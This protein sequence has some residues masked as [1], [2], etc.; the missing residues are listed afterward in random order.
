MRSVASGFDGGSGLI[1]VEPDGRVADVLREQRVEAGRPLVGG[2]RVERG[3]LLGRQQRA[4]SAGSWMTNGPSTRSMFGS[5]V[6]A[7]GVGVERLDVGEV[8]RRA[9]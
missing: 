6:D 5:A 9:R 2:Q 3:D 8:G 1:G 4:R 7:L